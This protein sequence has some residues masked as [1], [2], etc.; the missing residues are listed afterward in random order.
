MRAITLTTLLVLRFF[1]DGGTEWVIYQNK[2]L[3]AKYNIITENP[4]LII[5]RAK[6]QHNDT[7]IIRYFRDTPCSKCTTVLYVVDN[8]G[9]EVKVIKNKGTF[10]PFKIPFDDFTK[11]GNHKTYSFYRFEER[12]DHNKRLLFNLLIK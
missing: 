1:S 6:I 9:K 10:T 11:K 2:S 12:Y 3:L 5:N 8:S 7:L 4:S